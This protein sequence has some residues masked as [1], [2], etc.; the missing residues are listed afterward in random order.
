MNELDNKM[1]YLKSPNSASLVADASLPSDTLS[2]S[3]QLTSFTLR[4]T[5]GVPQKYFTA[6]SENSA[7]LL[8]NDR[9]R[10]SLATA[11]KRAERPGGT[12]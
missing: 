8:S 12:P 6:P 5:A 2:P 3:S 1:T 11:K 7:I 10:I 4:V 9:D